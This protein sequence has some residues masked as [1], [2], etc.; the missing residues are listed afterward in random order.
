MKSL[1]SSW[2]SNLRANSSLNVLRNIWYLQWT[3]Y[4][5]MYLVLLFC[6]C[7]SKAGQSGKDAIP[8]ENSI[9]IGTTARYGARGAGQISAFSLAEPNHDQ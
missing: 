2:L 8:D 1:T 6:V 7:T 3:C 4:R 5:S 9:N